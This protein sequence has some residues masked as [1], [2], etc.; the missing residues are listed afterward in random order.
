MKLTMIIADDE[1]MA[2]KSEELFIKKEFPEIEIIGYAENG[3]D[4]KN[5]LVEKEPDIAIVDI[6][7][8]GLTGIEAIELIKHKKNLKT[9]YIINTAYS[10]FDYIKQALDLKTDGYLLKPAKRD[11]WIDVVHKLMVLIKEE[12]RQHK[13]IEHMRNAIDVVNPVLESEILQSIFTQDTDIV[14]FESYCDI[15]NIVFECGCISTFTSRNMRLFDKKQIDAI[16]NDCMRGMCH[17]LLSV[18]EHEII[19]MFFLSN[20]MDG[21]Q[22]KNWCRDLAF[23]ISKK[24]E[25]SLKVEFI[26]GIGQIYDDFSKMDIS[27]RDSKKTFEIEN[28]FS[29]TCE[30]DSSDKTDLYVRKTKQYIKTYFAQEL[31]LVDCSLN[32]G[33]SPY[34]L[35]HIFKEKTGQTFIEYLSKIRINEAKKLALNSNMTIKDIS[36]RV[37]YF[38]IT[39]FCKV[40]KRLTGFTIG[41]YKKMNEQKS[42]EK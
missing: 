7:M 31:S 33:I 1:P 20:K 17:Y 29:V 10:D 34:Y 27:Y 5:M 24:L 9:H 6:R 42:E 11:E 35:S 2:L 16:L 41:E 21:T 8:P 19:I 40:F 25:E 38:N 15:N 12:N 18:T 39:Y 3:I 28:N 13:R 4:L 22:Q 36:E 26:Y 32:V 37:G 23:L 14:G 30:E